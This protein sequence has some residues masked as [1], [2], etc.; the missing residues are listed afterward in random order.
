MRH[1]GSFKAAG[2]LAFLSLQSIACGGNPRV[3][4]GGSSDTA[5][6][7]SW[8][9][10]LGH[11]EFAMREI[12]QRALEKAGEPA[13]PALQQAKETSRD[14]EIRARAAAIIEGW[15]DSVRLIERAWM[16]ANLGPLLGAGEAGARATGDSFE[17][18]P[19]TED[20]AERGMGWLA[21]NQEPDGRWDSLKFGARTK[22]DLA[23]TSLALLAHL[24]AG[25]TDL[26]GKYKDNVRRGLDWLGKAQRADGAFVEPGEREPDGL[27]HALAAIAMTE[28]FGMTEGKERKESAAKAVAYSVR[29]HQAFAHGAPSDFGRA[30]GSKTPDLLTSLFF[31]LQLKSA[32]LSGLS[33]EIPPF[34]G[35]LRFVRGLHDPKTGDYRL[36]AELPPS[37]RATLA[38]CLCLANLGEPEERLAPAVKSALARYGPATADQENSDVLFNYLATMAAFQGGADIF[39]SWNASMRDPIVGAQ[40]KEDSARGSWDPSGE[41]RD[42]GRV[43][44]TVLNCLCLEV[45]YRYLPVYKK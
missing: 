7:E 27:S 37:P 21:R 4:M 33:V 23:Q 38:A 34:E 24:G 15:P 25:Y 14:P 35:L 19:V 5:R 41:W 12:A 40:R 43:L 39:P 20:E 6:I 45:Y 16:R 26:D 11:E 36:A 8:I 22:A 44:A 18:A 13:L 17:G 32:K 42:G 9:R 31:L 1:I 10:Q 30:A 29:A 2:V 3:G 28:A